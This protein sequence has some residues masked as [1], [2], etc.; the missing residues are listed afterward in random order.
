[1]AAKKRVAAFTLVELLVVISIIALLISILLPSLSS[2]REQAKLVKCLAHARGM[3]QAGL[4]FAQDHNDRFQLVSSGTGVN[5]A[6][7]NQSRYAYSSSG[8]LLA[9]PVALAQASGASGFEENWKWGVRANNFTEADSR[10]DKMNQ[11]FELAICPADKAKLATPFYPLG[12][13]GKAQL[14]GT[15]DPNNPISATGSTNYWGLLSYGINEDLTGAQDQ[16]GFPPVF[17]Y[18][19]TG[20]PRIGQAHPKAGER[21]KGDIGKAW[22]PATLLL[23]SDAGADS[24]EEAIQFDAGGTIRNDAIINLIITAQ[25]AGPFLGNA[26]LSWPQRVPTKRHPKGAIDVVFADFHGQTVRPTK[27]G[28]PTGVQFDVP[29]E[30]SSIVR[31]SPYKP[32]PQ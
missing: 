25:A 13:T 23:I 9:W 6:D 28:R 19:E 27:Y 8:E 12:N 24:K 22:D 4:V 11:N 2:A 5:N 20:R 15:G 17:R 21:L 31:V 1:M 26:M 14:Q 3:G 30:Y 29:I 32:F 7:D 18:D 10:K 16:A